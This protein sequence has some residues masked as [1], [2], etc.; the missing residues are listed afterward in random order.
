M[1]KP[2]LARANRVIDEEFGERRRELPEW[3]QEALSRVAAR[4]AG[5]LEYTYQQGNRADREIDEHREMQMRD[6]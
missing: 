1:A 2:Y 3:A 5:D 6:F 4:L